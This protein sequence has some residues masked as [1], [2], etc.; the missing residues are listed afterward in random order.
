VSKINSHGGHIGEILMEAYVFIALLRNTSGSRLRM[1]DIDG[2]CD[3][4]FPTQPLKRNSLDRKPLK[5]T[6]QKL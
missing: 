6:L 2:L 3:N 5:R 1:K 4:L